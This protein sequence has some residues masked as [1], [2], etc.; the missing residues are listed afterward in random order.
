MSVVQVLANGLSGLFIW[1]DGERIDTEIAYGLV[2]VYFFMGIYLCSQVDHVQYLA[3]WSMLGGKVD[4]LHHRC[5]T[6][7]GRTMNELF[8]AV[9]QSHDGSSA[10]DLAIKFDAYLTEAKKCHTLTEQMDDLARDLVALASKS[11]RDRELA[12]L[13]THWLVK[14]SHDYQFVMEKDP[15]FAAQV[16][17][18]EKDYCTPLLSSVAPV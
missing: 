17:R 4:F 8:D 16:L 1:G 6:K 7:Y 10:G 3:R 5:E 13:L 18:L 9:K 11:G 14:H 2:Y 15:E 12:T